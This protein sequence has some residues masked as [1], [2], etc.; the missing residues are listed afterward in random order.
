MIEVLKHPTP[1]QLTRLGEIWLAGNMSAHPFIS[2][3]YWRAHLPGVL[4]A[5][6]TATLVVTK[7]SL[8]DEIQGFLGLVDDLI[9]GIF[10][11]ADVR[12]QGLGQ[13]LLH[14][15]QTIRDHLILEVYVD[16]I[17][18]FAL[19]QRL[20]FEVVKT[21]VD[22]ETDAEEYTMEWQATV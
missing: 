22:P 14:Y 16:N 17:R 8:T 15:A 3:A 20:G 10:V 6:E 4:K 5:F 11:A 1:A 12:S 9:A 13:S 19:Y 7:D 2:A 18:A 21:A